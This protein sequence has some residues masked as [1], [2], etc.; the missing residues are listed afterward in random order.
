MCILQGWRW[1]WEREHDIQS[2]HL[3]DGLEQYDT[4]MNGYG[5]RVLKL[6]IRLSHDCETFRI[7]FQFAPPVQ[8][9]GSLFMV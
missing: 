5:I 7:I 6:E 3:R 1:C 4:G 8:M 9:R 2:I